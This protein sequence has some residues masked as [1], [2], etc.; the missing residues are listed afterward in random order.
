MAAESFLECMTSLER[1]SK[2]V[3]NDL[4]E[5]SAD[6]N[7][8]SGCG[9]CLDNQCVNRCSVNPDDEG[10]V[11][12]KF[13]ILPYEEVTEVTAEKKKC[14]SFDDCDDPYNWFC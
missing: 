10:C 12:E 8:N 13:S 2:S 6:C 5:T 1:V 4:C 9:L 11:E 14:K 7:A 3:C